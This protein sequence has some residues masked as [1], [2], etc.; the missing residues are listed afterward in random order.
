MFVFCSFFSLGRTSTLRPSRCLRPSAHKTFFWCQQNL[1]CRGRWVI[2]KSMPYDPIQGQSQGHGGPKFLKTACLFRRCANNQKANS[3]LHIW[4]SGGIT[5]N[6]IN[7]DRKDFWYS[8][9]FGVTFKV[10]VLWGIDRQSRMRLIY[11]FLPCFSSAATPQSWAWV[12]FS[13]PNPI[14]S[15]WPI[16]RTTFICT[17]KAPMHCITAPIL[18]I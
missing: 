18:H 10:R 5:I 12:Q 11:Y 14:Q 2:I 16:I 4:Y 7:F 15:I 6:F 17:V 1:V 9:L 13:K 8:S 3:E